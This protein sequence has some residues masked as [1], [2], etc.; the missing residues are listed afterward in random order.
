MT[1]T[2]TAISEGVVHKLPDDLRK[3]LEAD[4]SALERWED[5]TPLARNEWI[6]WTITVKQE[7]TR[8]EHVKRTITELLEGKRRPCC[9]IGC[10]HRKDKKI[11]PSVKWALN[12][13]KPKL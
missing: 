13:S 2:K 11:S 12:K 9:W 5:L 4:E 7:K 3:A 10:I 1:M 6:C 8:K